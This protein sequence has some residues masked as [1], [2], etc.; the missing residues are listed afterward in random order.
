LRSTQ[1]R[2]ILI[3]GLIL[4]ALG[5][6]SAT[7][8]RA[9]F[10]AGDV[11]GDGHV[12]MEDLADLPSELFDG[13]GADVADVASGEFPGAA[14]ADANQDGLVTAA[15][16]SQVV[17]LQP[18]LTPAVPTVTPTRPSPTLTRTPTTTPTP[19]LTPSTATATP[20][21]TACVPQNIGVG[22]IGGA[23]GPGDC[24]NGSSEH[25]VDAYSVAAHPGTALKIDVTST[26]FSP[27]ILLRDA[28]GYF[29][30]YSGPLP[31]ELLV[32]TN[33]PYEFTVT[34][35]TVGQPTGSYTLTVSTRSC[36]TPRNVTPSSTGSRVSATLRETD[37]PDPAVPS[38]PAHRF[39]FTALAGSAI[40]VRMSTSAALEDVPDPVITIY[41][42]APTA[43]S[44][45]GIEL[46][47]DDESGGPVDNGTTDA[48]LSFYAVEGGTYTVVA[49]GGVGPYSATFSLPPCTPIP[50]T[51]SN[52]LTTVAGTL[53]A[54][55][56][57][58]PFPL[59]GA[60]KGDPN[61][62]AG[63]Y[64]IAADAGDVI[65]VEMLSFDFDA[66]LYLLGPDHTVVA[67]DDDGSEHDVT[68][69]QLAFTAPQAGIYTVV[70]ASNDASITQ[71]GQTGNYSLA[72]QKCPASPLSL[73]TVTS[74]S[75]SRTLDCR[76]T[77]GVFVNSYKFTNNNPA[78]FVF[79]TMVADPSSDIDS[80]L[81]LTTPSGQ[82]LV[83]DNDPFVAD[84]TSD[85]RIAR[86]LPLAGTYFLTASSFQDGGPVEGGY[87]VS[88]ARCRTIAA[89]AGTVHGEFRDDDCELAS[90]GEEPGVKLN[91]FT[92]ATG[93]NQL[94]SIV[95][96]DGACGLVATP[97]GLQGPGPACSPDFLAMPLAGAGT[98]A[99]IVSAS[100][101]TVRG[102]YE[103]E[104]RTCPVSGV[105][106]FASS[107]VGFISGG[108]C[109]DASGLPGDFY[110]F[111][112]PSS[113]IAFNGDVTAHLMRSFSDSSLVIDNTGLSSVVNQLVENPEDL[114]P[115]GSDLVF[116]LT[117]RP[118]R[119][120]ATGSYT[121]H[122]EIANLHQ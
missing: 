51:V 72:L 91:V 73:D 74:D 24:T 79:A 38:S 37:C 107:T 48:L 97:D 58:A 17:V 93:A 109:H 7:R 88:V 20:T 9:Q 115:I 84:F 46:A 102:P 120:D 52:Q 23:L 122:V 40:S 59:P 78:Q 49:T 108:D 28:G 42:P 118:A 92:M 29:K 104:L 113:L 32:T 41:G 16:F 80:V 95:P 31:V 111:R 87:A 4:F 1:L 34:S 114:L 65:A 57:P 61:G 6:V 89:A 83:N 44:F 27:R 101:P 99:V 105:I 55:S 69:A 33:R 77:K 90:L 81:A 112:A 14:G 85:A 30:S 121:L 22:T 13:D 103:F 47:S 86:V 96:P 68:D 70:A 62:R 3:Y 98:T 2:P 117:V 75:F 76:G 106:G 8:A 64:T 56:C 19:N 10:L 94:V 66:Q 18:G 116:G 119:A 12:S 39:T 63:V 21:A 82:V 15:D 67:S 36:P 54:G 45:T 53:S 26:S 100:D 110:L 50:G 11:N 35:G 71:E 25:F 60:S 5:L 43:D